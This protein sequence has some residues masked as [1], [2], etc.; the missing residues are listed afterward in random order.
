MGNKKVEKTNE[1][2]KLNIP[3]MLLCIIGAVLIG[4][5][6]MLLKSY[7]FKLNI[8]PSKGSVSSIQTA[9]DTD[10]NISTSIVVAYK[11]SSGNYDA[12]IV[13]NDTQYQLG[14]EVILY[15]DFFSPESVSLN[16][17]GYLGYISLIVGLI[18]VVKTGPRFFRIIRDNYLI[19]E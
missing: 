15:Y 16:P 19:T 14:N 9:K 10:G 8:I 5:G 3:V 18:L 4:L 12:T 1:K 2:E 7:N 13:A 17:S 6:V 11:A